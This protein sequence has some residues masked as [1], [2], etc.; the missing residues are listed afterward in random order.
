MKSPDFLVDLTPNTSQK[1][2]PVNENSEDGDSSG[3]EDGPE[4]DISEEEQEQA[5]KLNTVRITNLPLSQNGN[6]DSRTLQICRVLYG[7]GFSFK[8]FGAI[9][10]CLRKLASV[11]RIEAYKSEYLLSYI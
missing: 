5:V 8:W 4:E 6:K 10:R 3:E 9:C 7:P 11:R 1:S 2:T